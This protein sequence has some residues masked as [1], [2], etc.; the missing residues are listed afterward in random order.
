MLV[1]RGLILKIVCKFG[2]YFFVYVK[3]CLFIILL[4]YVMIKVLLLVVN[5]FKWEMVF[6]LI[7]YSIGMIN[8]LYGEK[9]C[10][11]VMMLIGILCF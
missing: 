8:S 6:L 5:V 9:F 3:L 2:C 10:F 11:F 4:I 7:K 1:L